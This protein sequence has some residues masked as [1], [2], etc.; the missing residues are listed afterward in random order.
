ML[1]GI[2]FH[3]YIQA[4]IIARSTE[5]ACNLMMHITFDGEGAA[6]VN[7][8]RM[9]QRITHWMLIE[10]INGSLPPEHQLNIDD[11]KN[12]RRGLDNFVHSNY[13][14]LKL[15]PA[16]SPGPTPLDN[17]SFNAITFWKDLVYLYIFS[18]L[19]VVNMLVPDLDSRAKLYLEQLN[20]M[21]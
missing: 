21:S 13:D 16:Q 14:A 10:K 8:L 6:L 5:D 11:Y 7:K 3:F 17:K 2:Q 20:R 18:C 1:R 9:G 15:Y 12:I 4:A 19:I